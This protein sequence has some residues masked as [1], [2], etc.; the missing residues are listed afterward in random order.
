MSTF[1]V[2]IS[3][4][5][6]LPPIWD[7]AQT[8]VATNEHVALGHAYASWCAEKPHP[9]PPALG[10]CRRMVKPV[11]QTMVLAQSSVSAE[12]HAFVDNIQK[13]VSNILSTQLDGEFNVVN[14][15]SGFNY[16]ITY[17]NNA[18][19]NKATLQ[20]IDTLL[21][22]ASNGFMDLTGAGF[23]N[24][25]A[26]V[27]QA[28]TFSFSQ[29]DTATMNKQDT[30][31]SSQIASILTEFTNAG[32]TFTNPLP[33]GGK[34]QDVFNQLT[35]EYT[36]LDN[37]PDSLNALR[38][39]I[40]SY[41][42]IAG[43]SYALHNRYYQATARIAAAVENVTAPSSKNGGMQVDSDS[44]YVGYTPNK[45]PTANQLIG[46]LNTTSN[47][48]KVDIEISDFSS[49][50]SNL[51]ISG[52]AG[53]DIP[54]A[55]ILNLS[56]GGSA[57][58]DLSRYTSSSSSISME[59]TYPGVTLFASMPS[60]L[61]TNNS[62]GWYANDI[63][64]EVVNKTGQD[65]TGYQLQGTEYNVDELF[66][67]GK[68]FSRL[69]TFVI[70]QQPTITMVFTASEASLITSDLKVGASIKLDLFGLFTLGSASGSYSVQKV[71]A[72]SKAGSVTVTFG[73]PEV[74]GTIPIEQQVAYVLGGVASYPPENV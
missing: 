40:A 72:D 11:G 25:Y 70:S 38:N 56:I 42:A 37:L 34:L 9:A 45:L 61:E 43:D 49:T 41:K 69:K 54:I 44:Y 63:L 2:Y 4:P 19:Y 73:P 58:Y 55:D 27:L 66:G 28:V 23:S 51:S 26:Q 48:V 47:A 7:W 60:A 8:V 30:A 71:D 67:K 62:E 46:G 31:A 12:Q 29:Q 74:S 1:R 35:K 39:A 24:L 16:G 33:F 64:T 6:T 21:G 10:L 68:A 65:S 18:Y 22:V 20:D 53:F 5:T 3:R 52:G 32:G 14:Y 13:Q 57:S 59:M 36:S 17:G 15:P 50:S